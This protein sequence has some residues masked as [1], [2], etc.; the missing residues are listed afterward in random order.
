MTDRKLI[1]KIEKDLDARN[2]TVAALLVQGENGKLRY[3]SYNANGAVDWLG[4]E[5]NQIRVYGAVGSSTG[6][7][8]IVSISKKE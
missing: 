8:H 7:N 1:R 2:S 5:F 3:I 4:P 6:M